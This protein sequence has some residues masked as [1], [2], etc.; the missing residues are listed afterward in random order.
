MT[1]IHKNNTCKITKHNSL[2]KFDYENGEKFKYFFENIKKQLNIT[3]DNKKNSFTF[4]AFSIEPL[5]KLLKRKNKLSYRHLKQLFT[6][7][8]KQLESLEKD[9]FGNIFLNINDIVRIET[10]TYNQKGGSGK[11][12]YFLYLNTEHFLP[13]ENQKIKIKSVNNLK[14]NLFF[15]PE[16]K[17]INSFPIDI[18]KMSQYFSLAL[19]VCYC[20]EWN[21]KTKKEMHNLD[22]SID[23]FKN[24]LSNIENTK[25][26]WSLLRCLKHN[27]LSRIYLY[28]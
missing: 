8:G 11:D 4:K 27:P 14:N 24:Y 7:I 18:S 2:Y 23:N 17:K 3:K 6:N 20:G 19:L 12:I 16:M 1:I 21:Y 15:S 9:N 5:N 10:N 26:Y 28:I 22:L 25:L 13:I